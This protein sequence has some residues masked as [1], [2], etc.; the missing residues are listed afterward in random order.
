MRKVVWS[1]TKRVAAVALAVAGA[2]CGEL[3]RQGESASYVIIEALEAAPGFDP[4]E[5]TAGLSSDVFTVIEGVG[6]VY[7]D[8]GRVTMRLGLKDPGPTETPNTPTSNNR[9]TITRYRVTFIRADGRN[10]P[11]VDVPYGF[12]GAFTATLPAAGTVSAGFLLVRHTAKQEA[13]LAALQFNGIIIDTIA[14]I[15]FY[16]HDQTGRAVS[17]VGRIGVSFGNFADP[18][19]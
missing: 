4:E 16:G 1:F 10:T 18:I 3:T 13:P 12:D 17:V 2:S 6:G 8:S 15:T 7:A 9:I 5:F 19:D 11:G 14:E